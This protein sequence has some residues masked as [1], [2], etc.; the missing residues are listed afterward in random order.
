MFYTSP[1]EREW[2]AKL[3][4]ISGLAGIEQEFCYLIFS[5]FC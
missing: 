5:E 1:D 3:T 2:G 4:P